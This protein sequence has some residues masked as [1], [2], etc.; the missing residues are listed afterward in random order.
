LKGF[1]QIESIKN[2]KGINKLSTALICSGSYRNYRNY[3]RIGEKSSMA[4]FHQVLSGLSK[5]ENNGLV[6]EGVA[7]CPD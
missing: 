3:F 4:G 7:K 5:V 6:Q 1:L 2:D